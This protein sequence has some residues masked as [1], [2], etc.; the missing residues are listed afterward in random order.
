MKSFVLYK[1][2]KSVQFVLSL[3]DNILAK[4]NILCTLRLVEV[5]LCI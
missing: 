5:D 3:N 1:L 4:Q 2:S